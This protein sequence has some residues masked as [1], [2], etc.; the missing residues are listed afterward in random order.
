MIVSKNRTIFG[1]TKTE[2]NFN[3]IDIQLYHRRQYFWTGMS[4][5]LFIF[6]MPSF[7]FDLAKCPT[8]SPASR[9]KPRG[10][11]CGK[12]PYERLREREP[13]VRGEREALVRDLLR[14]YDRSLRTGEY[15]GDARLRRGEG[16]RLRVLDLRPPP[17]PSRLFPPP[18]SSFTLTY[19]VSPSW[20]LNFESS[21]FLTAYF[22]SSYL[23]NSTAPVPS[24]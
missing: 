20:D 13:L 10:S 16:L 15:V 8:R 7:N 14:E 24:L 12:T 6:E 18:K 9:W 21:S 3:K 23:R 4:T 17:P 22:I 11:F 5:E 19:E 2:P 1:F